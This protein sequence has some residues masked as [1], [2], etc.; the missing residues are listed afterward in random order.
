MLPDYSLDLNPVEDL[1][2]NVKGQ[3]L[4]SRCVTGLARPKRAS[5]TAWNGYANLLCRF[6]F[7]AT[8]DSFFDSICHSIMRG[9][10]ICEFCLINTTVTSKHPDMMAED[11]ANDDQVLAV[12]ARSIE[13]CA[14]GRV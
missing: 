13:S 8:P 5:A 10:V 2:G 7:C 1:W 12:D 3:E 11:P 6:R 4:A 14:C 9:S